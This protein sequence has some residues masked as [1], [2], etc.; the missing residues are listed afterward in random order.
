VYALLLVLG[1]ALV[2]AITVAV[3]FLLVDVLVPV[4][5]I[6]HDDEAVNTW[7]ASHRTPTRNDLSYIGS[8][9]GDVPVLPVL[10]ALVVLVA[11][12]LRR[13]R[14]IAFVLGAIL[15]EVATYR[16]R[17]PDRAPQPSQRS[18][19]RPPAGEPELPLGPR[20]GVRRRLR[21]PRA[22]RDVAIPQRWVHV[23]AWTLALLL[24]LI[25]A[26]SRMYRG[27]HQPDRRRE[28]L[29]DGPRRRRLCAARDAGAGRHRTL[30]SLARQREVSARTR[31]SRLDVLR[32]PS[33]CHR[34][35]CAP[36]G[37][38]E[39]GLELLVLGGDHA[40]RDRL[41]L[42]ELARGVMPPSPEPTRITSSADAHEVQLAV[43]PE[44]RRGDHLDETAVASRPRG[45]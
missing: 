39:A 44:R 13:W 23:A 12:A 38:R 21:R 26:L 25:V 16:V 28:R 19:A 20:R 18:P 45:T 35:S 32:L 15:V 40:E 7:F 14:I 22:A 1:W 43:R 10:V 24:P 5:T 36:E 34:D 30:A 41:V 31:S 9:I 29:P 3:G 27:M 4:H 8:S 2:A 17:E 11:A 42:V 33:R 6:G 37:I